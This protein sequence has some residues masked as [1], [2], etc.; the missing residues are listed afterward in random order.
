MLFFASLRRLCAEARV[1]PASTTCFVCELCFQG[2]L[3]DLSGCMSEKRKSAY[4][5]SLEASHSELATISSSLFLAIA[6]MEFS[7]WV[8]AELM[9]SLSFSFCIH[10]SRFARGFGFSRIGRVINLLGIQTIFQPK[11]CWHQPL[12]PLLSRAQPFRRRLHCA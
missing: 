3:S 9:A 7:R 1:G 10:L 11:L 2:E 4:S 6:R 8:I 5:V 12:S